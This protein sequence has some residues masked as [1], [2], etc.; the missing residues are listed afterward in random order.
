MQG[1]HGGTRS[2]GSDFASVFRPSPQVSNGATIKTPPGQENPG[3]VEE[4][5]VALIGPLTT[6]YG[7]LPSEPG[8]ISTDADQNANL[9]PSLIMTPS[10]V[11]LANRH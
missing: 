7:T 11:S 8:A 6:T 4:P 3:G 9:T 1:A 10:F 5:G 2:Q